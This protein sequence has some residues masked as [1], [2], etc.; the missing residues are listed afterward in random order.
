MP[1]QIILPIDTYGICRI[2]CTSSD[3]AKLLIVYYICI[4]GNKA[5][6]NWEG[7]EKQNQPDIPGGKQSVEVRWE[8]TQHWAIA[9]V[10]AEV[11]TK[12]ELPKY[13]HCVFSAYSLK[14]NQ[15]LQYFSRTGPDD[16]VEAVDKLQ[17]SAKLLQKVRALYFPAYSLTGHVVLFDNCT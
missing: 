12:H 9:G 5:P 10:S 2:R 11:G 15:I 1:P 13:L 7:E 8:E 16:H 3:S 17:K 6:G 14:W 4:L